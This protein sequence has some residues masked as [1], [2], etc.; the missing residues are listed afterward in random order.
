M[1]DPKGH[2]SNG[3][4][5]GPKLKVS[6]K[7]PVG[8]T[9]HN[10]GPGGV[11]TLA[12]S[13]TLGPEASAALH[14]GNPKSDPVAVHEAM[15]PAAAKIAADWGTDDVGPIDYSRDGAGNKR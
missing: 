1:K 11:K 7:R 14:S 3:R 10:V 2:G 9:I 8:Y 15:T 12:A 4:G 6:V 13:G 5:R